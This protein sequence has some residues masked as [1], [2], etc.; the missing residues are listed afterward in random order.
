MLSVKNIAKTKL[1]VSPPFS[2]R[3]IFG[4]PDGVLSV[5]EQ[6]KLL[7]NKLIFIPELHGFK[8]ENFG[9]NYFYNTPVS[10]TTHYRCGGMVYAALDYFYKGIEIPQMTKRPP[11]GSLLERYTFNRL[12]DSLKS[13]GDEFLTV[14]TVGTN[15]LQP[16]NRFT[17]IDYCN[18]VKEKPCSLGLVPD[19]PAGILALTSGGCHQVLGVGYT[20]ETASSEAMIHI[21]DPNYP[22][23]DMVLIWE[24]GYFVEYE[25]KVDGSLEK[26]GDKWRACFFDTGYTEHQPP[27]A[28]VGPTVDRSNRDLSRWTPP[29]SDLRECNFYNSDFTGNSALN[30]RDF[31]GSNLSKAKFNA[32]TSIA[33]SNFSGCNLTDTEFI[34]ASLRYC[35][36]NDTEDALRLSF[37]GATLA[38]CFFE[39]IKDSYIKFYKATLNNVYFTSEARLYRSDFEGSTLANTNF[40]ID[41]NL[42]YA[43]FKDSSL[44]NVTFSNMN[45]AGN[46]INLKY[47]KFTGRSDLDNVTFNGVDLAGANFEGAR[48]RSVTFYNIS[49]Y[50]K[51]V[52]SGVHIDNISG[53]PDVV[54]YIVSHRQ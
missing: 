18:K 40:I 46:N 37:E 32:G 28:K 50:T 33:L 45:V 5:K 8:F 44:N 52:W 49:N 54:N 24:S 7:S 19:E 43:N 26:K 34:G 36:F 11:Y 35:S 14:T 4:S 16:P 53:D 12:V 3:D 13:T 17:H 20:K 1:N 9:D 23:K 47:T 39:G 48:F 27:S 51:A 42:Q 10:F 29:R 38:N 22:E 15:Q 21:Y 6:L 2:I 25:R 30:E 31:E 41:V